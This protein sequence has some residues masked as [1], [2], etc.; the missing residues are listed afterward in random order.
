MCVVCSFFTHGFYLTDGDQSKDLKATLLKKKCNYFLEM[1]TQSSGSPS[2]P[3]G[4]SFRSSENLCPELPTYLGGCLLGGK[5]PSSPLPLQAEGTCWFLPFY[6]SGWIPS[7]CPHLAHLPPVPAPSSA[8]V[9]FSTGGCT[10]GGTLRG[11]P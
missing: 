1:S 8:P 6:L 5:S 3:S 4:L 9:L 10:A 11:C 2:L 7:L